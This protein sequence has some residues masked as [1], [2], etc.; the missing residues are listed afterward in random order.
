MVAP[1]AES[2]TGKAAPIVMPNSSGSAAPSESAPVTDSACRIPTAALADCSSAVKA[3]PTR[4]PRMGFDMLVI[5]LV[6][7]G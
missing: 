2:S 1:T 3:A 5:V 4:M 7:H 6:N